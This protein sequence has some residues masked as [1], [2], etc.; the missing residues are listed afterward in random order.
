MSRS[1]FSNSSSLAAAS[2]IPGNVVSRIGR[3]G[4]DGR[5]R[6]GHP[7]GRLIVGAEAA[8][9]D[10]TWVGTKALMSR[11]ARRLMEGWVLVQT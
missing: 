10:G 2:A 7:S 5:I 4:A 8:E 1:S 9:R 11:S 3:S 6:I